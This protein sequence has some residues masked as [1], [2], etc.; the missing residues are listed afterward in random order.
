MR[1]PH[2]AQAAGKVHSAVPR[3]RLKNVTVSALYSRASHCMPDTDLQGPETPL[4]HTRVHTH[5]HTW[6]HPELPTSACLLSCREL[7]P[8]DGGGVSDEGER[9]T[10]H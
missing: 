7:G 2:G 9:E 4:Q 10:S 8:A 3:I 1:A 5:T 6:G